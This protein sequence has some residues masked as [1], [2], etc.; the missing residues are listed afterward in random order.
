MKRWIAVLITL[1]LFSQGAFAADAWE[2]DLGTP[3]YG[4]YTY[5]QDQFHFT[6][7]VSSLIKA[8]NVSLKIGDQHKILFSFLSKHVGFRGATGARATYV[9]E[10]PLVRW[11][12]WSLTNES[13]IGMGIISSRY[14]FPDGRAIPGTD[15]AHYALGAGNYL[16]NTFQTDHA[17]ISVR[18]GGEET[19]SQISD[20]YGTTS[21][22]WDSY[23]MLAGADAA[24]RVAPELNLNTTASFARTRYNPERY[25][26]VQDW[27][28]EY[29]G[30]MSIAWTPLP[31][32][33]IVPLLGYDYVDLER[34]ARVDLNRP[35][36]GMTLTRKHIVSAHDRLYVRG[37]YAPWQ[38]MCGRDTLLAVGFSHENFGGEVYRRETDTSYSTFVEKDVMTGLRVS[39]RFGDSP[40]HTS[41]G[42]KR[43][44]SPE[45][46]YT[47]YY[48]SD[49]VTDDASLSRTQQ[50]E[51]LGN[52]RRRIDWS[53]QYLTWKE[54]PNG[55]LGFRYQDTT[56]AGRAGDCD[57]QSCL[58][59]SMDRLNGYTAYT[60][61][62]WDY[63]QSYTGHAVELVQDPTNKQWFWVEY[64]MAYKL[65]ANPNMTMEQIMR[66]ALAQ[67]ERFSALPIKDPGQTHFE[68]IQCDTQG[69]YTV[70][71][72][73]YSLGT[74][75]RSSDRPAFERGIDLF[76]DRNFVLGDH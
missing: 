74:M 73:Y 4:S 16:V 15:F 49:L 69:T 50:A 7:D 63:A 40:A 56:Y 29:H 24:W 53:G 13:R 8:M 17:R 44:R 54:A 64:G 2:T 37:I 57:E 58:N 18:V 14:I 27:A 61:A 42:L 62:W 36:F 52:L 72:P 33:E 28:R 34:D 35:S 12:K 20:D 25:F 19:G 1:C 38:Q 71:S 5:N 66:E 30:S 60:F 31:H 45:R 22:Q 67:N 21:G 23:R 75:T 43:Y 10:F 32:W 6:A 65:K 76:T 26:F 41:D 11:N 46:K 3:A 47:F 59:N 70:V 9:G 48:P 39:W 68:L 55:G 51:R